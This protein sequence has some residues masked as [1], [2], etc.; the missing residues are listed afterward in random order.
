MKIIAIVVMN[1]TVKSNEIM[2]AVH[3]K[4]GNYIH[5]KGN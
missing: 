5:K 3:T 2:V 1:N 4:I